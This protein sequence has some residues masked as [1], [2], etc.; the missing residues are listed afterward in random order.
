M[1]KFWRGYI[2]LSWE[3]YPDTLIRPI[4]YTDYCTDYPDWILLRWSTPTSYPFNCAE[5]GRTC[6]NGACV[7]RT[8]SHRSFFETG[9]FYFLISIIGKNDSQGEGYSSICNSRLDRH[10]VIM[11]WW[12]LPWCCTARH[13]EVEYASN[14]YLLSNDPHYSHIDILH[15]NTYKYKKNQHIKVVLPKP[16]GILRG[17]RMP[18]C[19][20]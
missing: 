4:H 3:M 10:N 9:I 14:G 5:N 12:M 18:D 1:R 19:S 15:K 20:S 13:H 7:E 8:K 6:M 11:K 2:R 16:I 17:S